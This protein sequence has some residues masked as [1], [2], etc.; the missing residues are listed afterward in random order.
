MAMAMACQV[1]DQLA[2]G[3]SISA[4]ALRLRQQLASGGALASELKQ[5]LL[6]LKGKLIG[7]RLAAPRGRA[8]TQYAIVIEKLITEL[9]LTTDH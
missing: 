8:R 7:R 1:R 9:A 3:D 5:A 6:A 2:I 4:Y